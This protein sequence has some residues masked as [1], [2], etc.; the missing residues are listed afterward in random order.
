MCKSFS[1]KK[2]DVAAIGELLIDFTQNGLSSQGN[3]LM[4]ANPGGA[5][6][7]V[8]AMLTR[9]GHKTAF[10]GQ[11]GKDMFGAMLKEKVSSLGINV[12]ALRITDKYDTTLAFV[13]TKEGGD[14][15]FSFYR[16]CGADAFLK[17]EDLDLDT[18]KSCRILQYGT[19]SM[20]NSTVNQATEKAL[21]EAKEAGALLSF[22]PNLR[23]PLWDNLDHAK[24]RM[25]YGISQCHIL[26]IADNELEFL[27]GE[28]DIKKGVEQIRNSHDIKLITV[29][30]GAEGSCAFYKSEST[31]LYAEHKAFLTPDT[32][33]TTGAGDTFM[34]SILHYV[35]ENN[36]NSFTQKT[37]EEM[38][39]F[40]NA[41]ASIVTTRKGAL[42]VMPTQAEIN[43]QLEQE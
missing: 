15:D 5:P 10:I 12:D 27:T 36:L 16:R 3:W 24:E 26:K 37:L 42:C 6:C 21:S 4:E 40:A 17:K 39:T 43:K 13:H 9:L 28:K 30:K 8:L 11:V 1:N 29:T 41:A 35:L 38:L 14:R 25:W 31:E 22:D 18:I 19:L 2:Y 20:T 7:N 34:G 23:P 32:V 33:D